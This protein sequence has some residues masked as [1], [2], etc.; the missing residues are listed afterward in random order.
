MNNL[1]KTLFAVVMT[2]CAIWSVRA[3][4]KVTFSLNAPMIV[5]EGETFRAE[6]ALNAKP[7]DNSFVPP[8]FEGFDVL[9][10]P[11]TSQGQS[12]SIVNG[13]M[14]KSINYSITYVLVAQRTGE[15]R[16]GAAEIGVDGATYHTQET[17]IEVRAAGDAAGGRAGAGREERESESLEQRA[18]NQI[19]K[20]DVMLRLVLSRRSVYKGEPIRAALKLYSRVNVAGSEGAKMPA[21]NGFWSQQLDVEQGPFRETVGGK[22]Y[23]AYNIAEYL[24]Y[25]QQ[26]GRLTIEP[27][28]LTVFVQ[29]VVQSSR[30]YDP[31][32]GG[33]HEIYNVRRA[34]RTPEVTVDV[35]EFPAGAPASFTGAVGKYT[36]EASLSSKS[37]SA[38]S[39]ANINVR[40]A[41]TGNLNFMQPPVLNLPSSFELYDTKTTEQIRNSGSGSMGYRSFEY[42]F[43]PRAE[44]DYVIAPIEFTYFNP[45]TAK[46]VTL[47]S[48]EFAI[49]VTP[50]AKG[51]GAPS[52]VVSA[53]VRKED[54]RLLGND[55]RFIKLGRPALQRNAAPLVL[56][57]LYWAVLAAM[58]LL[59]TVVFF[60]VRKRMRDSRNTVLVHARRA[61]K[62]AVQ[63]FRKAATYMKE[64]N[65]HAFYE[66]M[67]RAL[68]GYISDRFNIPVA[69]LTKES[70]REELSR[71]GAVE[72][73]REIT[74]IISMCEEAQYSPLATTSMDEV[75]GKG[76]EVVSKIESVVKK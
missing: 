67:L 18:G 29:V 8:S 75:Y 51:G 4:E 26:S 20:D 56:S 71:R 46:Y 28:E 9:A 44:G 34:L 64:Q 1:I 58:V 53:G 7:D 42:P 52:A 48:E 25:P 23:E 61:N 74:E 54:V 36:M 57:P 65:R 6:F 3:D 12:I 17:P 15:L 2:V 66:E 13:S 43:I 60:A 24:L 10:G 40:I 63:R 22:V 68:W 55:I 5:A 38:N 33:G 73:A 62:V 31:F 37:V 69:D 70:I 45:E 27:A 39:A 35:R 11:A 76:I 16:I 72:Q 59:A 19:G 47:R 41:G 32:F 14:T 50:D 49:S 30:H 21:F